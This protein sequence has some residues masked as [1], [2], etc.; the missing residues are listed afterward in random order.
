MLTIPL[1]PLPSQN[2]AVTLTDQF[3][4]LSVY[5]KFYGLFLDLRVSNVLIVAGVQCENLN[6]IVRDAYFGFL[7]DFV[8]TDLQGSSDPI[9]TGLGSRFVLIYLTPDDLAAFGLTG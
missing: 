8:F 9:F 2:V 6:R 5:Q 3:V 4:Q 1:K 7:G